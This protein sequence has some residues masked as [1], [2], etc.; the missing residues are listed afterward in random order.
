MEK[1]IDEEA[2]D[3][4]ARDEI[5]Q[6]WKT[7]GPKTLA[8][9]ASQEIMD[10]QLL[11]ARRIVVAYLSKLHSAPVA[12]MDRIEKIVEAYV[13]GEYEAQGCA[14]E[15]ILDDIRAL[16]QEPCEYC[17]PGVCTGLPGNACENCMNTGLKY[18]AFE[19]AP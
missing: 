5:A 7:Y 8:Q 10:A 13:G 19:A 9:Y 18:P 3:Y 14:A 2:L 15:H 4:A 17:G 16:R 11:S 1:V 6:R 12:D